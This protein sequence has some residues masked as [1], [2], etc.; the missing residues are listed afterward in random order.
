MKTI[1]IPESSYSDIYEVIQ[2]SYDRASCIEILLADMNTQIALDNIDAETAD[3][4]LGTYKINLDGSDISD[5][6]MMVYETAIMTD[7]MIK[8]TTRIFLERSRSQCL[9][10]NDIY[11]VD[12]ERALQKLTAADTHEIRQKVLS[13][14]EGKRMS[15]T[16]VN[17]DNLWMNPENAIIKTEGNM[18]DHEA[19]AGVRFSFQQFCEIAVTKKNDNKNTSLMEI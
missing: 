4:I 6:W 1:P 15:V 12:L 5:L 9:D 8:G 13:L 14:S 7:A 16:L 18:P 3:D 2:G 19:L 11:R 10:L 17:G